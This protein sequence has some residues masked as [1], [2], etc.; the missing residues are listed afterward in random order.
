MLDPEQLRSF[1]AVAQQ[2]SFTAAA[3]TLGVQQSTVSQRVR[4]L[5]DAVGR[6]LLARDTHSVTP[7]PDGEAMVGFATTLL[8]VQDSALAFFGASQLRGSLRFGAS[9]DFV[10]TQLPEILRAFRRGYPLVDLQLTVGLSGVL[11]AQLRDGELDA[12]LGKRRLGAGT[13]QALWRDELTWISGTT[14]VDVA[15]DGPVPLVCFPPPSIT[16][17]CALTALE[18]ARRPWRVA[19]TSTSLSGISAALTAGLGVAVHARSLVP[20]GLV[21]VGPEAGLPPLEPVEF[22]LQRHPSTE[23]G[24][25]RDVVDA[26]LAA[27]VAD[28]HR[29]R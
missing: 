17:A 10:A 19:C 8:E 13:G 2:R 18:D 9:E 24:P 26:L 22:V 7:T 15:P 6:Q 20:P 5:E 27:V 23:R 3:R 28:V 1:L 29:L 4:R 12:V 16:R 21:E 14:A 25:S 11:D